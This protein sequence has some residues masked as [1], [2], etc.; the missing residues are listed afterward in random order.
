MR[1]RYDPEVDVLYVE[2]RNVRVYD[3]DEVEEGVIL[4]FGKAGNVVGLE[5]LDT[6]K[7]GLLDAIEVEIGVPKVSLKVAGGEG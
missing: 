3:S 1:I 4:H 5:I 2:L 6:R 7:R